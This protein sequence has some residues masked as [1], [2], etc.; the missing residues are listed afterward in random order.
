MSKSLSARAVV[1]AAGRGVRFGGKIPKQFEL[2]AGEPVFVHALRAIAS[3][4]EVKEIILVL[5]SGNPPRKFKDWNPSRDRKGAGSRRFSIPFRCVAGGARRQDSVAAGLVAITDPCDVILVHDA[6]RPFPPKDA[7]S[8]LIRRT[9]KI[10]GGLLAVRVADTIKKEKADGSVKATLDRQGLWLAQ[11]PQSFRA[12]LKIKLLAI[13]RR[14]REF[15]DE[16]S[17]LEALEIPVALVESS[18][19]NFKITRREDF[20][21]A[22]A[23]L[24]SR[25]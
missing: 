16:A 20:K 13:L 2:L 21:L 7:I 5:P 3:A 9:K 17:A 12:D 10:G 6:A 25:L 24:A 15:T 18:P 14:K 19:S 8:E 11:T 1:L 4:P 22:E 23:W